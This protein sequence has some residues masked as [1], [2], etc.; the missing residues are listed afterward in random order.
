M[1]PSVTQR[2]ARETVESLNREES[3]AALKP[4]ATKKI[5]AHA[6]KAFWFRTFIL[7]DAACIQKLGMPPDLHRE[8]YTVG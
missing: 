8:S 7:F 3:E 2:S 4:K 5:R 1:A 6:K